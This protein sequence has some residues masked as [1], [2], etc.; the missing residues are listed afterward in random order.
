ME[1]QTTLTTGVVA[2]FWLHEPLGVVVQAAPGVRWA[3]CVT[4]VEALLSAPVEEPPDLVLLY[5]SSR[6][7][8]SQVGEIKAAWPGVRCIVL[9]ED[10][11]H[12]ETAL[13]AGADVILLEGLAPGRLLATLDRVRI[14]GDHSL[15]EGKAP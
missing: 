12:Q 14:G 15:S 8:A 10:V 13:Q 5:V 1:P 3:G 11:R 9:V 2:P 4:T 6:R 7:T